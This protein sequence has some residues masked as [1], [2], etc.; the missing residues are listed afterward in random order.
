MVW[1]TKRLQETLLQ[2]VQIRFKTHNKMK[3]ATY[4]TI[5]FVSFLRAIFS[6]CIIVLYSLLVT[7]FLYLFLFNSALIDQESRSQEIN[8]KLRKSC[9]LGWES[10]VILLT[11]QESQF[12]RQSLL[13]TMIWSSQQSVPINNH[14]G[15]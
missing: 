5:I 3:L 1:S 11:T 14:A 13:E 7:L 4:S 12:L 9:D 2:V 6:F 8:C 15:W 10:G